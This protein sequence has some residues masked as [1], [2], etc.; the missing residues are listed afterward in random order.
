MT[1]PTTSGSG[2]EYDALH[3]R[4]EEAREVVALLDD[5]MDIFYAPSAVFA[6]ARTRAFWILAADHLFL[7]GVIFLANRDLIDPIME[8]SSRER[9]PKIHR[10]D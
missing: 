3:C 9:W 6:R 8:R 10:P 4:A 1:Q 7:L 2:A 5:F